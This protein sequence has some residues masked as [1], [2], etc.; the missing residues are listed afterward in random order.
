MKRRYEGWWAAAAARGGR[1]GTRV[2]KPFSAGAEIDDEAERRAAEVAFAEVVAD[3]AEELR[4]GVAK[5]AQLRAYL[6]GQ[7]GLPAEARAVLSRLWD[8]LPGD[9][10]QAIRRLFFEEL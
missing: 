6:Q 3:S 5:V 8:R 2:Q 9:A 1:S 10:P 7:S 4:G